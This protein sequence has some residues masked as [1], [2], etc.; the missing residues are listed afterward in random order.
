M[1][2]TTIGAAGPDTADTMPAIAPTVESPTALRTVRQNENNV[3]Q[4][5]VL[6]ARL[7]ISDRSKI[8]LIDTRYHQRLELLAVQ[9]LSPKTTS[10]QTRMKDIYH[11][12]NAGQRS[13]T[14][15]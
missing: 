15:E 8:H 13:S 1:M 5:T 9:I 10:A 6:H 11:I 12:H 7:R 3:M 14:R 2:G 4:N